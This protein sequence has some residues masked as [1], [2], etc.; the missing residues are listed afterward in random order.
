[1]T[2]FFVDILL[3]IGTLAAV[4]A[5]VA[6]LR[7][8]SVYARLH[9]SSIISSVTGPFIVLAVLIADGPGLNTAIVAVTL[10]LLALTA[11]VLSAAIGRLNARTDGR[12]EAPQ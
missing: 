6:A 2:S 4:A 8:R 5:S 3:A 1:M 10:L 11:P 7:P 9:Y 12:I